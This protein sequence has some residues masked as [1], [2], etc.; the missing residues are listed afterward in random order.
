MSRFFLLVVAALKF[1]KL[2]PTI[3]SML[4]A[5]GVYAMAFGWRYAVGIV[6]ML[7]LHEMGHYIA[8]RQRGLKVRLPMFIPFAFAWTTLEDLP[9]DAETEAY[10]ALA[11]PMLG[12]VAAIGA[13]FLAQ[14]DGA[15][16][17]LAVAYTGFFL[18]LINM[19]PLPPLDGGRITAVL[20]PRIWLLGVPIV[21]WLLWTHFSM[22]LLLVAILAGPHV[23]AALNMGKRDA[24]A[25]QYYAV[26]PRVRWEYG[27]IY[28]GLIAFLAY[29]TNDV[30]RELQ[31]I[32]RQDTGQSQSGNV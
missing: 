15:H 22:I 13:Y 10:I 25:Q 17:L 4:L 24:Q 8:A 2:A 9:H 28:V 6:A 27:L 16:W 23:F 19:I 11:G 5:I 21:G 7:L 1:G 29:M 31:G 12:T 30:D 14:N 3:L 20:S 26:S 18:N 32:R